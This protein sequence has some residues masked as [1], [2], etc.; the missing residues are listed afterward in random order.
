MLERI[1]NSS[2][3]WIDARSPSWK[4]RYLNVVARRDPVGDLILTYRSDR[5]DFELVDRGR[6]PEE[7]AVDVLDH[8]DVPAVC[9]HHA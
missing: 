6:D 9:V 8:A 5:N 3:K 2:L 4:C 1:R 7:D